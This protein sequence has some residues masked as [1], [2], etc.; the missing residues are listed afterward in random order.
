VTFY[1]FP[2]TGLKQSKGI[3][4]EIDTDECASDS[5]DH[6]TEAGTDTETNDEDLPSDEESDE[7]VHL[8]ARKKMK[9]NNDQGRRQTGNNKTSNTQTSRNK[10]TAC[11]KSRSGKCNPELEPI[12][13]EEDSELEADPLAERSDAAR[14]AVIICMRKRLTQVRRAVHLSFS[15]SS[16]NAMLYVLRWLWRG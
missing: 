7:E 8:R 11:K 4:S 16:T 1:F 13:Q 6:E 9:K 3:D 10:T 15:R 12:G 2:G 5:G 14:Q